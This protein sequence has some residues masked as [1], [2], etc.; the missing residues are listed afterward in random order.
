MRLMSLL[1]LGSLAACSEARPAML[2]ASAA[3][4][5]AAQD[6][7]KI[8]RLFERWLEAYERGDPDALAALFTADAVYAA[9]TGEL[10]RD[11]AGI[12]RGAAGWMQGSS[13]VGQQR[14]RAKLDVQRRPLRFRQEGSLAYDLAW[15]TISMVPPGCIIDSGHALAVLEKQRDGRWLIDA[16]TV[17][18]DK[19]PP[20]NACARQ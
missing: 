1:L 18:Q 13:R 8:E 6:R 15:F 11:R 4:A 7:V 3:P 20:R 2:A 12:L 16:L 10:L 14:A 19:T 5:T 17:N 9:N